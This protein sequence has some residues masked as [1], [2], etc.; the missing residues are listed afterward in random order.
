MTHLEALRAI[1]ARASLTYPL[2]PIDADLREEAGMDGNLARLLQ[3]ARDLDAEATNHPPGGMLT[4]DRCTP[5]RWTTVTDTDE[6][7]HSPG[8]WFGFDLGFAN[9][10]P[11]LDTVRATLARLV[12]WTVNVESVEPAV[13]MIVGDFECPDDPANDW[14]VYVTGWRYA[15]ENW[16]DDYR[17]EPV[18]IPLAGARITVY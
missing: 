6:Q 7:T 1:V 18:R 3:A 10:G 4:G 13:D 12:G 14:P 5:R 11:D 16:A 8:R 2:D 9:D 15:K 17:G